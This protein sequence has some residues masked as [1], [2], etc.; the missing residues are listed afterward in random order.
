MGS[1]DFAQDDETSRSNCAWS[2][3]CAAAS[4]TG[5]IFISG[6]GGRPIHQL[7]P[8]NRFSFAKAGQ[9]KFQSH[10]GDIQFVAFDSCLLYSVELN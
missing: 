6:R 2:P 4:R 7:Q 8:L 9:E 10:E 5:R 3:A 1:F